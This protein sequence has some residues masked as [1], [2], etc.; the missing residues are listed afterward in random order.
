MIYLCVCRNSAP[1]RRGTTTR[2]GSMCTLPHHAGCSHG[3][4]GFNRRYLLKRLMALGLTASLATLVLDRRAMA[5]IGFL[6]RAELIDGVTALVARAKSPELR[7]IRVFDLVGSEL[8][9]KDLGI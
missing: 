2:E 3:V 1:Q 4:D 7:D 6:D 8:P 9:W 5:A